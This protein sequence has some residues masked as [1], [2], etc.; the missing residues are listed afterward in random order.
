MLHTLHDKIQVYR[1]ASQQRASS[2]GTQYLG[3]STQLR[4][5]ESRLH[6]RLMS[7]AASARAAVA[8]KQKPKKTSKLTLQ[9]GQ[10]H[11]LGSMTVEQSTADVTS[12][13]D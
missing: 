5:Q 8:T 4:D 3:C 7:A 6:G 11:R 10:M 2:S 12:G 9:P 13:C 1:C